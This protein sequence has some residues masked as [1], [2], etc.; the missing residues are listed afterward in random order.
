MLHRKDEDVDVIQHD[1][2][3]GRHLKTFIES[4]LARGRTITPADGAKVVHV[5]F[6]GGNGI[7]AE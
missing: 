4:R 6:S 2:R 7:F 3:S 5:P 1:R